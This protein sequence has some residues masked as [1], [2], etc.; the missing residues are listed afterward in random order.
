MAMEKRQREVNEMRT[1]SDAVAEKRSRMQVEG[2][3]NLIENLRNAK[4]K[5][6]D[7]ADTSRTRIKDIT[8]KPNLW[9]S[10]AEQA[11]RKK[12]A[13]HASMLAQ[14]ELERADEALKML[15]P[16]ELAAI[17]EGYLGRTKQDNVRAER[18]RKR[19]NRSTTN[20]NF[21]WD[22]EDDTSGGKDANPLY[23]KL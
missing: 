16:A 3:A 7:F 1:K 14:T 17:K 6:S 21:D 5:A 23:G 4:V 13:E 22:N 2:A 11:E 12:R 18:E 20:F 19:Q 8:G 15:T 9:V 10:P